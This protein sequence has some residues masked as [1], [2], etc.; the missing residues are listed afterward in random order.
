MS[1]FRNK[2][3]GQVISYDVISQT[4]QDGYIKTSAG[5]IHPDGLLS[6]VQRKDDVPFLG[7]TAIAVEEYTENL[8][9]N[10]DAS[11]DWSVW[12]LSGYWSGI[13][14]ETDPSWGQTF[15]AKPQR[16]RHYPLGK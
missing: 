12:D 16:I 11:K 6:T 7:I 5:Y 15:T 14:Y 4:P 2:V 3:T 8:L 13:V 1:V 9:G 10:N